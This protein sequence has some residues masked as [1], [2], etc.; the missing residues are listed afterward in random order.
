MRAPILRGDDVDCFCLGHDVCVLTGGFE[1]VGGL[2]VEPEFGG[3]VEGGGEQQGGVCGDAGI[4]RNDARDA[5]GG[6]AEALGKGGRAE[7]VGGEE[8]L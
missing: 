3:N 6:H 4:A 8:F 2:Q 1:V 5:V 7:A